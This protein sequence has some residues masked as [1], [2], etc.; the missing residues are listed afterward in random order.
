MKDG[1]KTCGS[2]I[3]HDNK[4]AYC[5][6]TGERKRKGSEACSQ[7]SDGKADGRKANDASQASSDQAG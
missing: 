5:S 4:C 3:M 2:C 6:L 7:W 1:D